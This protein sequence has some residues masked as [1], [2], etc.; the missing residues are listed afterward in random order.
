MSIFT[1]IEVYVL[2][3]TGYLTVHNCL[4]LISINKTSEIKVAIYPRAS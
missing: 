4:L 1:Y 2:Y 3:I